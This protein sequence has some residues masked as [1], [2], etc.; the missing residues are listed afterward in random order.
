MIIEVVWKVEICYPDDSVEVTYFDTKRGAQ[1][2]CR[3]WPNG[4]TIT[5]M[6]A[7]RLSNGKSYILGDEVEVQR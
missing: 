7:L 1:D 2:K 3:S 4:G 5:V 6:E